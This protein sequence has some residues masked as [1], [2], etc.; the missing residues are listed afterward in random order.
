[1]ALPPVFVLLPSLWIFK[2]RIS[3][4]ALVGTGIAIAGVAVIFLM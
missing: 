4:Q 1:M 2:D 3:L